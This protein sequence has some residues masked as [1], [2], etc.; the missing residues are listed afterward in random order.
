MYILEYWFILEYNFSYENKLNVILNQSYNLS[1]FY[2]QIHF[3]YTLYT[4]LFD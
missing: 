1:T 2:G 3:M 4:K